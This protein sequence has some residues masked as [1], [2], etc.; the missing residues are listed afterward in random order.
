MELSL[1]SLWSALSYPDNDWIVNKK[2]GT[3]A[4]R[5][6]GGGETILLGF[7][8]FFFLYIMKMKNK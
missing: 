3:G 6:G 1:P 5:G 8:F 4:W 7:F 2:D